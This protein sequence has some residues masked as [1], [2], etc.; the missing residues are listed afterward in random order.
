MENDEPACTRFWAE[1]NSH[2]YYHTNYDNSIYY[3]QPPC[4]SPV[5]AC[6]TS[7]RC[8]V[9]ANAVT[10][11][12]WPLT[13]TSGDFCARNGTTLTPLPTDPP[14]PN[15]VTSGSLTFTSPSVY[16]K[17]SQAYGYVHTGR[18]HR[19]EVGYLCG[20]IATD[21]TYS[22]DPEDISTINWLARGDI[23]SMDWTDLTTI[24]RDAFERNC[25]DTHCTRR[26]TI[27][28]GQTPYVALPS[29]VRYEEREWKGCEGRNGFIPVL[30]PLGEGDGDVEEGK[31]LSRTA[32][33]SAD[34]TSTQAS[35][36]P[37]LDPDSDTDTDGEE[38]KSQVL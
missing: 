7:T 26:K 20:T 28:P 19:H 35:G 37:T 15:T 4:T 14:Y 24:H 6:P 31:S 2:Y 8:S 10:M 9:S 21:V 11:Y 23:R 5:V 33:A 27:T 29:R 1:W 17:V 13:T 16:I 3:G 25:Y 38:V 36:L 22:A 32:P 30:V 34:V 12:Y 18:F